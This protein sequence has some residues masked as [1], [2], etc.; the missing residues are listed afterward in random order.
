MKNIRPQ[1]VTRQRITA[2]QVTPVKMA[3]SGSRWTRKKGIEVRGLIRPW[4]RRSA[5]SGRAFRGVPEHRRS[6]GDP[7]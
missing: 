6:E 1:N 5:L 4:G 7:R 3:S 2:V